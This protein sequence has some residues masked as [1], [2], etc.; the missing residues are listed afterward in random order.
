MVNVS[1]AGLVRAKTL[2]GLEEDDVHCA[3]QVLG[4]SGKPFSSKNGY[5]SLNSSWEKGGADIAEVM[6]EQ[7]ISGFR[8]A[9]QNGSAENR[10]KHL[11]CPSSMHP[12][13]HE[14]PAKSAPIKFQTA[15]GR[16]ISISSDALKRARSLLGDPEFGSFLNE[17]N[18]CE[19][20]S[21]KE[22]KTP[23]SLQYQRTSNHGHVTESFVSPVF[24][25]GGCSL[26]SS[27]KINGGSN[28][29]AQFDAAASD[30][31]D[32]FVSDIILLRC[33]SWVDLL[34]LLVLL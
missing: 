14:F 4:L 23:S 12:K 11:A 30:S 15:G 18:L 19:N 32:R 17:V 9:C 27:K 8:L 13:M 25:N 2:L 29:I 21:N 31:S 1:A 7:S 22:N 10:L 26:N 34:Y 5:R 33:P 24:S 6:E 16:S 3:S 28:L 20:P